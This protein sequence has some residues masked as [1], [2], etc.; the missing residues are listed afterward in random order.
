MAFPRSLVP[1]AMGEYITR[2]VAWDRRGI[3]F[4]LSPLLKDFQTL[5]P[6]FEL[7]VGEQA[8]KYYE[9]PELRQV[10]FYAMLQYKAERLWVLQDRRFSHCSQ[11]LLSSAGVHS[12]HGSGYSVTRSTKLDSTQRPVWGRIRE[13]VHRKRAR[14]GERQMRTQ[15]L[16][17]QPPLKRTSS[18]RKALSL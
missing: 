2:H 16:S 14:T 10:I 18:R 13:P 17:K 5:C 7:T 9:L 12:S 4:P 11:R 8:A 6:G 1:K 15:P 3:A